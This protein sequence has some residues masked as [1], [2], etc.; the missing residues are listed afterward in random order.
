[1][2]LYTILKIFPQK[3]EWFEEKV[4]RCTKN[5]PYIV[6]DIFSYDKLRLSGFTLTKDNNNPK[7]Q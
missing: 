3:N 4:S 5:K 1:M 6:Y 2:S 7:Y